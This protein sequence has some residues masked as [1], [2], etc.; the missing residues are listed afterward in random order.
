MI[1][2]PI[3]HQIPNKANAMRCT[4]CSER[5]QN[6]RPNAKP[7]IHTIHRSGH[8][9]SVEWPPIALEN[10]KK[11]KIDHEVPLKHPKRSPP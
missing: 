9:F 6:Q 1:C 5:R 2:T 3:G 11:L 7:I 8:P 10:K 4:R